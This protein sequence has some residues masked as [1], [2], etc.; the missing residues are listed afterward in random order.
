MIN[1]KTWHPIAKDQKNFVWS[2]T[3][4]GIELH[5]STD[6]PS[7]VIPWAV[8]YEVYNYSYSL[9]QK[10]NGN[11]VAGLSEDN[12]PEGSIG[13]WVNSQKFKISKNTLTSRHLSF[14]GPIFGHMGFIKRKIHKKSIV[15]E[16]NSFVSKD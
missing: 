11:V 6:N 9:A 5:H 2:C 13:K 14:L 7:Y 1:C 16:F 15:W 3:Q 12:P 8:F 10:Q 4:E